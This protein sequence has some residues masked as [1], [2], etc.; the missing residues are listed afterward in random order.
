MATK[1]IVTTVTEETIVDNN[2]KGEK[3]TEQGAENQG[4]RE[5]DKKEENTTEQKAT[6][7]VLEKV[8]GKLPRLGTASHACYE[9]LMAS[10]GKPRAEV[11]AT[12]KA[13]ETG[14][15]QEHGRTP[16]GVA[17]AGWLRTHGAE[18]SA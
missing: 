6:G 9:A 11:L 12:L 14:W 2:G 18:F 8:T 17:P 13:V 3:P 5:E 7:P 1:K 4:R 16:K 10:I 15:H